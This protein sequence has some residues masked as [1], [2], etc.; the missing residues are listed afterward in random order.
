MDVDALWKIHRSVVSHF[1]VSQTLPSS[2]LNKQRKL[3]RIFNTRGTQRQFH[4]LTQQQ[5]A[6]T[7]TL[8]RMKS[9]SSLAP[10]CKKQPRH[11]PKFRKTSAYAFCKLST[12]WSDNTAPDSFPGT[13]L[14]SSGSTRSRNR[15]M[16]Y[17]LCSL[18][19]GNES[20]ETT[21]P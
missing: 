21:W 2:S 8:C 1:Y 16:H 17:V 5:A 10:I 3:F 13:P 20:M 15:V 18:Q 7:P 4:V 14:L 12:S 19:A 9:Q 11:T 6:Y